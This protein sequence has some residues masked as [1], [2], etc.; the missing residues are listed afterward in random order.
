MH[1]PALEIRRIIV[2]NQR[3]DE[4]NL[5]GREFLEPKNAQVPGAAGRHLPAGGQRGV[6][7]RLRPDSFRCRGV[8]LLCRICRRHPAGLALPLQPHPVRAAHSV[9]GPPRPGIFFFGPHRFRRTRPDRPRS[10][11]LSAAAELC[12]FLRISR[13][14]TGFPGHSAPAGA[15]VLRV[16]FCRHHLPPRRNHRPRRFLHP[17]FL[18]HLSGTP[19]PTL[20]V[21]AF[22]A[23]FGILLV[24]FLLYRQAHGERPAVGAA[25]DVSFLSG[26]S[27]RTGGNAPT[28]RPQD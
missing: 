5:L 8:F 24:R 11:G 22:A 18:G 26:R 27:G 2:P 7:R 4:R 21:L 20:A 16:G 15:V 14:R 10:R 19:I 23:A 12:C 13:T 3:V 1:F 17:R 25:G 28:W 6:S 9:S